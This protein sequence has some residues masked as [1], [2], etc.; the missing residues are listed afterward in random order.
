MTRVHVRFSNVATSDR[1]WLM[2]S[3][4]LMFEVERH[5]DSATFYVL[6]LLILREGRN[7]LTLTLFDISLT[8]IDVDI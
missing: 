4:G 2:T 1:S 6:P 3:R 7:V 5:V 8:L